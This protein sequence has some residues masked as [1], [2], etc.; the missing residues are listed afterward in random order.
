M[1]RS[2]NNFK[3]SFFNN[4]GKKQK[5]LM[6]CYLSIY[7]TQL[8]AE[9][10]SQH[11]TERMIYTAILNIDESLREVLNFNTFRSWLR[12]NFKKGKIEA[13]CTKNIINMDEESSEDQFH[14]NQKS[15]NQVHS[16][17]DFF[18]S[19]WSLTKKNNQS[20][21]DKYIPRP[22]LPIRLVD[23][24]SLKEI[25]GYDLDNFYIDSNGILFDGFSSDIENDLVPIPHQFQVLPQQDGIQ[26]HYF[27]YLNENVD[28][29]NLLNFLISKY[30]NGTLSFTYFKF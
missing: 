29:K 14:V 10:I 21:R 1:K 28:S 30:R 20:E 5:G 4:D 12:K 17:S 13:Q 9:M 25:F 22:I 6:S 18:S 11:F 19:T 2:Y 26:K 15:C 27:L 8:V 7:F 24:T 16:S 3:A 23:K